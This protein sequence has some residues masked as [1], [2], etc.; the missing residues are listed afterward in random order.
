MKVG[1][2]DPCPC[3][4]GIKFKRCCLKKVQTQ[5][6]EPYPIIIGDYLQLVFHEYFEQLAHSGDEVCCMDTHSLV[7]QFLKPL[8]P[9]SRY[10]TATSVDILNL[11]LARVEQRMAEVVSRH[12][13]YYWLH[14]YR[15]LAPENW[16][17]GISPSSVRLAREILECAFLKYGN[18]EIG[19]DLIFGDEI[20]ASK[21]MGG[22]FVKALE[23]HGGDPLSIS[24]QRMPGGSR[25]F[26]G[27]FNIVQFVEMLSLERLA[28][29]YWYLTACLRRAYKG[30]EL[31]IHDLEKYQVENDVT[32]DKLIESYDERNKEFGGL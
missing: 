18:F 24:N 6:R 22:D 9:P 12:H 21:I 29:E 11:L 15:R 16:L 4:S 25:V 30:G 14:L 1:R 10:S 26:I 5:G 8:A 27:N 17:D 7:Q 19:E 20:H 23:K 2:N 28:I 13:F 31:V 3:G 32:T